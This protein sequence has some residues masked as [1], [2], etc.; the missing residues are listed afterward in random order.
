MTIPHKSSLGVMVLFAVMSLAPGASAQDQSGILGGQTGSITY[1]PYLRLALGASDLAEDEGYWHPPGEADP[2]VF[3]ELSSESAWTGSA[4]FGFDWNN[5]FR[6]D[7]SFLGFS[8]AD[9]DAPWSRTSPRKPG[10]HANVETSVNSRAMMFT[11]HYSPLEQMGRYDAVQPFLSAGIGIASNEMDNWTRTNPGSTRPSRTFEGD[12][13]QDFAWSVG[14]GVAMEIQRNGGKRPIILETAY[15]Y[16]DLGTM[17]GGNKALI[18]D[19]DSRPRDPFQF[20]NRQHV[21]SV[22]IRIPLTRY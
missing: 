16:Y 9:I 12:T 17:I 4:A 2:D 10:P 6:G 18:N 15:G 19:G 1:G 7:V 8:G 11:G 20:D 14:F 5:G 21:L 3:F 22:G 13:S